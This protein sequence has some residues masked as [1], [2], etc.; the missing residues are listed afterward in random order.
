MVT[1]FWVCS[2]LLPPCHGGARCHP[3]CCCPRG[4]DPLGWKLSRA[5]M[6]YGQRCPSV[7]MQCP[8]TPTCVCCWSP[9]GG[10][11]TQPWGH[12][13]VPTLAEGSVSHAVRCWL[14]LGE[15][16][17]G[18]RRRTSHFLLSNLPRFPSSLFTVLEFPQLILTAAGWAVTSTHG[19]KAQKPGEASDVILG[20]TPSDTMAPFSLTSPWRTVR[21]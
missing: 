16:R 5:G 15:L 8:N 19:G 4:G 1:R 11:E 6:S 18:E 10:Q 9:K 3:A 12:G 17:A 21:M 20:V 7:R 14:G 13:G 2:V